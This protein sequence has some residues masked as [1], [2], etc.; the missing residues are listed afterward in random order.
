MKPTSEQ[1]KRI[2]DERIS[3]RNRRSLAI[4]LNICPECG[5]KIVSRYLKFF[6]R[7]MSAHYAIDECEVNKEHYSEKVYDGSDFY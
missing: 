6:Q 2:Q 5:A 4:S 7:V 3:E 1:L